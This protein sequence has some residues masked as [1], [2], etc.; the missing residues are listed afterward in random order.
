MNAVVLAVAL[1]LVLSLCRVHVVLGLI[2][3]AVGGGLF[4]G[5]WLEGNINAFNR[6]LRGGG[7]G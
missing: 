5:L 2:I 6:G 4:G 3:G 7:S 1:I